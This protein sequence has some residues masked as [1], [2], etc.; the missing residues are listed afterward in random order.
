MTAPEIVAGITAHP[1][2]LKACAVVVV[3]LA[4]HI[5]IG[6]LHYSR[7]TTAT[8]VLREACA[9]FGVTLVKV[10]VGAASGY[11]L[12]GALA[13]PYVTRNTVALYAR[14]DG[15]PVATPRGGSLL[16]S[17]T[18]RTVLEPQV[19]FHGKL[20]G[21]SIIEQ[22]GGINRL[23]FLGQ[24]SFSAVDPQRC[25]SREFSSRRL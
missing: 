24:A 16:V 8:P 22:F 4:C 1:A 6:R 11:A 12:T 17:P 2:L 18:K 15:G 23:L 20:K 7:V 19:L 3:P 5:R 14:F 21:K 13:A 25:L 9:Y 10:P